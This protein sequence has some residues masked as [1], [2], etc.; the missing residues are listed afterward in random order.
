MAA[1]VSES[2]SS[3]DDASVAFPALALPAALLGVPFGRCG[4][5]LFVGRAGGISLQAAM[6]DDPGAASPPAW[7]R[8]CARACVTKVRETYPPTTETLTDQVVRPDF[9]DVHQTLCDRK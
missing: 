2:T 4:G 9:P 3:S 8:G 7:I 5:G 1:A 6:Q